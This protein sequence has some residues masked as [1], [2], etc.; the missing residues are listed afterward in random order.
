MSSEETKISIEEFLDVGLAS[1][2]PVN[3]HTQKPFT[4]GYRRAG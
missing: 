1:L 4:V 3:P 2:L